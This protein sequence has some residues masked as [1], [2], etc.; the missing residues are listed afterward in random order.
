MIELRNHQQEAFDNV[1]SEITKGRG[2]ATGRVV[3]PTGAGK[4]FV[5]AALIDYQRA[6]NTGTRIHL[7]LDYLKWSV[8][9]LQNPQYNIV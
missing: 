2:S 5:E 3:M 8:D 6:N 4:T 9:I 7:V 1:V